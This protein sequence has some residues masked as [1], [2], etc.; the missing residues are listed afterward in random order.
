MLGILSEFKVIIMSEFSQSHY[1]RFMSSQLGEVNP[2]IEIE[3]ADTP[4]LPLTE[5][6]WLSSAVINLKGIAKTSCW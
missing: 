5:Q 4:A 6:D 2:F 3:T 1:Q